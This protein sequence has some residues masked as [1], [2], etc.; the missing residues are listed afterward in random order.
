[1]LRPPWLFTF[2]LSC[3]W[4]H[5]G[6]GQQTATIPSVSGETQIILGLIKEKKWQLALEKLEPIAK[7]APDNEQ[8]L[9]FQV[10]IYQGLGRHIDCQQKAQTFL[11]K[12]GPSSVRDQ[13]LY[14]FATS[15]YQSGRKKEAISYLEVAE[16]DTKDPTLKKNIAFFLSH[17]RAEVNRIGIRLGGNLPTTPEEKQAVKTFGL[18]I[19][20]MALED[21]QRTKGEYPSQ[22]ELLLEGT[23][24]F[25]RNLPE[26][27]DN[28][29]RTFEY[30][31]EGEGYRFPAE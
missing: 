31:K 15:L 4:L 27:P 7:A 26:D 16:K 11:A 20:R 28:P 23:P 24:P 1:M 8:V 21:Y 5:S 30:I 14:L 13:V 6:W 25:L 9:L 18:R 19:L 22:L 12:Y 29:G 2:L 17:W 3:L 10:A